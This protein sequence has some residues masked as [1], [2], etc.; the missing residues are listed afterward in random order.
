L[1]IFLFYL[2]ISVVF[3]Q[4][5]YYTLIFSRFSY[6]K[7][8][9]KLKQNIP[10]SVLI[11]CK[12]EAENIKE[13]IPKLLNQDYPNFEIIL[14]NDASTDATSKILKIFSEQY[15]NIKIVTIPKTKTYWGNKKNALTKGIAIAQNE[16]LLFTDADCVP[17]DKNWIQSM[18]NSFSKDKQLI[19]GYG[20]YKK[21]SS[22]LN[23]LIR[24]ET[25]LTAWQYFS[26]AKIGI[27][28][29]GVGRNMAYT[30]TLFYKS[31]G[32]KNHKHIRSGDDD[33]F[34]N[35]VASVH[36][37]KL[38]WQAHTLSIPKQ[39][40]LDWLRQKR[41]HITTATSY[42]PIHQLLL[43]M[44]FI[45]QFL[46]YLLLFYLLVTGFNLVLVL[47]LTAIRYVLYYVNLIPATV[48]LKEVDLLIWAPLL[49]F[50]LVFIQI[51]IFVANLWQRPKEW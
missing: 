23:K 5:L 20:G 6:A 9:P 24:Y 37:L 34:V 48:K 7:E 41:R 44:F 31:D 17:S 16:H 35:Q 46:F 15:K 10:I 50:I 47:L 1:S 30:K 36:N 40:L 39:N 4:I 19:L 29:M 49:D 43:G 2:F 21:S 51:R 22:W 3:V 14:V 27:P 18:S 13:N 38:N 33:L 8:Q 45:S 32:F 12:D 26:Y 28:Y 42:K 11:A 25:L